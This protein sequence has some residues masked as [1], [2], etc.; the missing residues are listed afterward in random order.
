MSPSSNNNSSSATATG[1][2]HS[3]AVRKYLVDKKVA[4]LLEA[5][6][7]QLIANRP[8]D[9]LAFLK[10][11]SMEAVARRDGE[12]DAERE[13]SPVTTTDNN[14]T[15]SDNQQ[16]NPK[17]NE[18]ATA[19]PP[20]S[21]TSSSSKEQPKQ[22]KEASGAFAKAD[23]RALNDVAESPS[24]VP[25]VSSAQ[26][27]EIRDP[28]EIVIATWKTFVREHSLA[29]AVI[30]KFF[31]MLFIQKPLLRRTVFDSVTDVAATS[32]AVAPYFDRLF[33]NS[34]PDAELVDI[35][36]NIA[37][38]KDLQEKHF[39]SFLTAMHAAVGA[40]IGQT[41]W[42]PERNLAWNLF[43]REISL[44]V[45]NA[46]RTAE[47]VAALQKGN[48]DDKEL[49]L[50][51]ND[52]PPPPPPAG[53]AAATAT[54][55]AGNK[56]TVVKPTEEDLELTPPTSDDEADDAADP[57]ASTRST[58]SLDLPTAQSLAKD[59]WVK[60]PAS[61]HDTAAVT[62]IKLLLTQHPI[63]KRTILEGFTEEELVTIAKPYLD[64]VALGTFDPQAV[65][66]DPKLLTFVEEQG[67]ARKHLDYVLTAVL[68]SLSMQLGTQWPNVS[69]AWRDVLSRY[70]QDLAKHLFQEGDTAAAAAAMD[71]EL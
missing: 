9:A 29:P 59:S 12:R 31:Q 38:G 61:S 65:G 37:V 33:T 27:L 35:C 2:S 57:A 62:T 71:E 45:Q 13:N 55:P 19:P 41:E 48:E 3:D 44:R 14:K 42:T 21:A 30:A 10:Q 64:Q 47:E 6:M 50:S 39:A 43:L 26:D 58:K 69:L 51:E 20:S 49:S 25:D 18:T 7:T 32:E 70:V 34:L 63:L 5:F 66:S 8:D 53:T 67:A 46:I 15:H 36:V 40:T 22:K 28:L 24:L 1:A 4:P 56:K 60:L 11:W 68:G 16:T 17:D 52:A 23:V 54:A